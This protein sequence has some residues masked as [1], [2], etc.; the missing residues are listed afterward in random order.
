MY[1]LDNI[2]LQIV[3]IVNVSVVFIEDI[4]SGD[5]NVLLILEF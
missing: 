3:I 5:I 4:V 2:M 1:K